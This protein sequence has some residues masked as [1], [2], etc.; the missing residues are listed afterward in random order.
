[1]L[2]YELLWQYGGLYVDA[3]FECLRPITPLLDGVACFAARESDGRRIA[4]GLMGATRRHPFVG[5]LI[6]GLPA[7]AQAHRGKRPAIST[8]PAYLTGTHRAHLGQLTVFP[9]CLFYP[10]LWSEPAI[11]GRSEAGPARGHPGPARGSCCQLG[12]RF[13][14]PPSGVA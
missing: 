8:G 6:R 1:M 7:S 11:L 5:Q 9:S 2:R 12:S 14:A 4:N 10:Y 13:E 3:D